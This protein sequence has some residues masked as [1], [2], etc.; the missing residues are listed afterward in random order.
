MVPLNCPPGSWVPK[1]AVLINLSLVTHLITSSLDLSSSSHLQGPAGNPLRRPA[2]EEIRDPSEIRETSLRPRDR[3]LDP[4]SAPSAPSAPSICASLPTHPHPTRQAASST[5]Q[6]MLPIADCTYIPF[7]DRRHQIPSL[8]IRGS[9]SVWLNSSG[10]RP[11][12]NRT[13]SRVLTD[14]LSVIVALRRERSFRAT[15]FAFHSA[16]ACTS[17]AHRG[18]DKY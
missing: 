6:V 1:L 4:P 7:I 9:V 15:V 8:A 12:S 11:P 3:G 5:E 18:R 13:S 16:R 10:G 17:R 14:A 2:R